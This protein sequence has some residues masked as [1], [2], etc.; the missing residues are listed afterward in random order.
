LP[1][2]IDNSLCKHC[3]KL[4]YS[5]SIQADGKVDG[6][7]PNT[8]LLRRTLGSQAV[9]SWRNKKRRVDQT[10]TTKAGLGHAPVTQLSSTCTFCQSKAQIRIM[11]YVCISAKLQLHVDRYTFDSVYTVSLHIHIHVYMHIHIYIYI[12]IIHIHI[13]TYIYILF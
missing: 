6:T 8:R 7:M 13:H 1:P 10:T 11:P 12:C 9:T 5:V 4:T 3:N 2:D